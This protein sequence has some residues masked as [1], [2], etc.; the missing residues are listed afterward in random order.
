MDAELKK[1]HPSVQRQKG[2]SGSWADRKALR[3]L[4]VV[5]GWMRNLNK[6]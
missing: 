4:M 6:R 3:R 1:Q 2:F 5:G